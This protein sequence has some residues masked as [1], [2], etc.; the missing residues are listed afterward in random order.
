MKKASA[1]LLLL[2][3]AIVLLFGCQQ[4][5][6]KQQSTDTN[7]NKE[8]RYIPLPSNKEQNHEKKARSDEVTAYAKKYGNFFDEFSLQLDEVK[9]VFNKE[10]PSTNEM[11]RTKN[12]VRKMI[13][14][15]E[16]IDQTKAPKP[17]QNLQ[18]FH[19]TLLVE[20]KMLDDTLQKYETN[21][22]ENV[23]LSRVYFKNILSYHESLQLEYRLTVSELGIY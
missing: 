2:L 10:R 11:N 15:V 19:K 7:N 16:E 5:N 6:I 3:T 20:L 14:L 4:S 18:Q 12:H 22:E 21:K 8:K 1:K 9:N 17:F 13:N 23:R